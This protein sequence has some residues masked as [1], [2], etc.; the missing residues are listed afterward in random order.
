MIVSTQDLQPGDLV[1]GSTEMHIMIAPPGL[2]VLK[3]WYDKRTGCQ[4]VWFVENPEHPEG[5][6]PFY[7][8]YIADRK[9][10][11]NGKA[12]EGSVQQPS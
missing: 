11:K 1:T 6:N 7:K 2:T 9:E 5:F 8:W 4:V 12:E 3:T 10:T